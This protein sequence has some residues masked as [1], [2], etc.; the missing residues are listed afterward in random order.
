MRWY[1]SR[2]PGP[3]LQIAL[4]PR[5]TSPLTGLEIQDGRIARAAA[6]SARSAR[7]RVG[8]M[9]S[10]PSSTSRGPSQARARTARPAGLP[11]ATSCQRG[12]WRRWMFCASSRSVRVGPDVRYNRTQVQQGC[13][14]RWG[15]LPAGS[16][17]TPRFG[18]AGQPW[19]DLDNQEGE[20]RKPHIDTDARNPAQSTRSLSEAIRRLAAIRGVSDGEAIRST[21]WTGLVSP[22]GRGG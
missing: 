12:A 1:R 11:G 4:A 17:R 19:V 14:H 20:C 13:P 22:P 7:E 21:P 18:G 5:T 3:W 8:L 6:S 15:P 10:S 16:S 2:S 9:D